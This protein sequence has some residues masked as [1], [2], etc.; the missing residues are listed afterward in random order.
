MVFATTVQ[1]LILNHLMIICLFLGNLESNA[2]SF[3]GSLGQFWTFLSLTSWSLLNFSFKKPYPISPSMCVF[4]F[5]QDFDYNFRI[6]SQL[7]FTKWKI[8]FSRFFLFFQIMMDILKV[9]HCC[10]CIDLRLAG[11][12]FGYFLGIGG[13]IGVFNAIIYDPAY[14]LVNCMYDRISFFNFDFERNCPFYMY[15]IFNSSGG[16]CII[17]LLAIWPSKCKQIKFNHFWFR[18]ELIFTVF[19]RLLSNRI[20]RHGCCCMLFWV[21]SGC[22]RTS[23]LGCLLFQC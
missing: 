1:I 16:D 7:V 9:N 6:L 18:F 23:W 13:M 11:M 21:L 14:I 22:V 20:N 8:T 5:L 2:N 15:E 3:R 10:F 12:I 17:H 19:F 4:H